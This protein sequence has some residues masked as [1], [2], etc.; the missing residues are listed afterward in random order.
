MPPLSYIVTAIGLAALVAASFPLTMGFSIIL[1]YWLFAAAAGLLATAGA[2]KIARGLQAPLWIGIGLASPGLV[3]AADH[4]HEL[5][6]QFNLGIFS[7]FKTAAYLALLAAAACAIRLAETVSLPHI[8]VRIGYGVLAI[9][10]FTSCFNLLAYAMGW[11]FIHNAA[12]ATVARVVAVAATLVKYGA[13]IA[14][15]ALITL[16][17]DVE[18]WT[19]AAIGL[20]SAYMLYNALRPLF[21]A[22]RFGQGDGLSFWLQPVIMLVGGAAVWRLGSLLRGPTTTAQPG[23]DYR[24][25]SPVAPVARP[26]G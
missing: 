10:A 9:A 1:W 4:L 8:V 2:F 17:R 23:G 16:R 26:I 7:A 3:W 25:G 19:G 14:A 15:A 22:D 6:G 11:T 13:F 24:D 5:I 12:Y 21:V 20:V 18:R